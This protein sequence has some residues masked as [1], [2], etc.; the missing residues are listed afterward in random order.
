MT[1]E[2]FRGDYRFLSNFYPAPIEYEGLVY[3]STEHAY[4]AA[5]SLDPA[6]RIEIGQAVTPGRAKFLG[7]WIRPLRPDWEQ[8]KVQVMA[9]VLVAKFSTMPLLAQLINTWGHELIEGNNWH[10]QFWGNCTCETHRDTPGY[11]MLGVL[12]MELRDNR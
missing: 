2:Y 9:T 3:P 10:D 7:G 5:K 12:L 8:V 6:K 11:N 1:I 4:Q